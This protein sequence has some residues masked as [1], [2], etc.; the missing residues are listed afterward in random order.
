[1]EGLAPGEDAVLDGDVLGYP[2]DSVADIPRGEYWVQAVLH[3]Y[4]TFHR[5][6]GH[7]LKLPIN[8]D[9]GIK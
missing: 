6:D 4:E 9:E 5:S 3:R 8:R 7:R 2:V 1:M